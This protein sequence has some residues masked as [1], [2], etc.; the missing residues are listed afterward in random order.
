MINM[1]YIKLVSLYL[2]ET[3]NQEKIYIIGSNQVYIYIYINRYGESTSRLLH[4]Y[5]IE[6]DGYSNILYYDLKD[7]TYEECNNTIYK[8]KKNCVDG[9]VVLITAED[10]YTKTLSEAI[11]EHK[12]SANEDFTFIFFNMNELT[13]L[14]YNVYIYLFIYSL[15]LLL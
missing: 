15:L 2:R 8:V 7:S 9:C 12:L 14:S 13:A 5:L 11:K 3:E 6:N 1:N 4:N 10:A